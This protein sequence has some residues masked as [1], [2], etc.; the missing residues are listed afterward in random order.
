M[1]AI[2]PRLIPRYIKQNVIIRYTNNKIVTADSSVF[3]STENSAR[4]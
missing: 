3:E 1:Q 4:N 2:Y